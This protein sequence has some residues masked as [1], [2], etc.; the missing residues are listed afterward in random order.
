M[1][2]GVRW[3]ELLAEA[4][5][6][7]ETA[8]I[9]EPDTSARRI[10]EEC[11][12]HEGAEFA[13]GLDEFVTE[14]GMASFDRR[15]ARR[16]DGEPLQYVLG[17]WSF[18][19]LDLFVDHRVLIP[20]PETEVVA[21]LAIDELRQ[22]HGSETATIGVDL[23][24]GSGA[25]GLSIAVEANGVDVWMTDASEDALEV[26]RANLAGLGI[27]GGRV[28]LAFGS[29]FDA[30]PEELRGRIAVIVSN[31]PY[32]A[33]HEKLPDEVAAWEPSR[34]LVAGPSGTED[35]EHIIVEGRRWLRS[36]GA[37]VLEMAP[38]QTSDIAELASRHFE[39]VRVESD[40]A[41][42]LRAVVASGPR[43]ARV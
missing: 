17:R 13:L 34:A 23:G 10:V 20:R 18:R 30:L 21:G 35:L 12:G 38:W 9:A 2:E 3:R 27:A 5:T 39:T 36:D 24:T 25:I 6:R 14:R 11:S 41:G 4:T 37:I 32:V 22:R 31:P 26:A 43:D 7:L 16:L 8:G 29:W 19:A 1:T 42:R 33:E 28:R 40:L 15:I